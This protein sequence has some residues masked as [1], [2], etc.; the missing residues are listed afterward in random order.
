MNTMSTRF[1]LL[2]VA[3]FSASLWAQPSRLVVSVETDANATKS[4]SV[5]G[6]QTE[7]CF[8]L[9]SGNN[10]C[11]PVLTSKSAHLKSQNNIKKS[12]NFVSRVVTV[13]A[14]LSPEQAQQMLQS[15]GLYSYVER[16]I[17]IQTTETTW[18]LTPPDDPWFSMQNYFKDN[19]VAHPTASSVL[20]L[21]PKL[22]AP[23]KNTDVYVLDAG[24]RLHPDIAYAGGVSF[25]VVSYDNER[26]PGFLE[27]DFDTD[28]SCQSSHGLGV[29]GVIAAGVNNSKDVTG[30]DGNATVHPI[31]V[32][33]CDDGFLSDAAYALQWLAG[34]T[35]IFQQSPDLPAFN[36]KPGVINMS[37]GGLV[38][39]GCP[40]YMQSAI[41]KVLAKGFVVT[42]SA[43]NESMNVSSSA[44]ANCEGVITVG[45]STDA[46]DGADADLAPFSNYGE[47]IDVMAQGMTV[48][49][50]SK[51]DKV[52]NWQGT[53]F[54]SP[55]VAGII[56]LV[57]KDFD[58]TAEQWNTLVS[59]SGENRWVENSQC[60]LLGCGAGILNGAKLYENAE[61][62][63]AGELNTT[64]YTLNLVSA[65]RQ[66]WAID[67][68]LP[69]KSLCD[70]V[71]VTLDLFANTKDREVIKLFSVA[72]GTA[73]A[74][75]QD[76]S[77]LNWLGD[78]TKS[79]FILDKAKFVNQDV[80]SQLC[81]VDTGSCGSLL[82]VNTKA[83]AEVPAACKS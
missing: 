39:N 8:A 32:M 34:D 3:L 5:K 80:Y 4:A 48:L 10:W 69:G 33:D 38:E 46:P 21:W 73:V 7:Q 71:T 15:S 26:R 53:S 81:N 23:E 42:V 11:V 77:E 16:D 55:L 70:Q 41:D 59:I 28:G 13:P 18:N 57:K 30:I 20:S 9:Q 24:F 47:K 14:E 56:G 68:L 52:V 2:S 61:R 79:R 25:T 49:G 62:M 45:A 44:P 65:C 58:F 29:S 76:S 17:A 82:Q 6:L 60:E 22:K 12:A 35:S 67:N 1:T 64:A 19:S 75:H 36:G 72:T 54:S 74:E 51:D 27:D 37:L 31:R 40:V 50:L 66:Q 78:F 63:K 43:G 83:L